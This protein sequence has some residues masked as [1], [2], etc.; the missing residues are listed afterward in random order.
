MCLWPRLQ[1]RRGAECG[2]SAAFIG[3]LGTPIL[4]VYSGG[5][6]LVPHLARLAFTVRKSRAERG[7]RGR[8]NARPF[9]VPLLA[10][11]AFTVKTSP[12]SARLFFHCKRGLHV[13]VYNALINF[14]MHTCA[15]YAPPPPTHTN[16]HTQTY[17]HTHTHTLA[18]TCTC[19]HVYTTHSHLHTTYW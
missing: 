5:L 19:M 2:P 11:W 9:L 6:N 8:P 14:L 13:C 17:T 4:C 1:C 12:R 16:T 10:F 7:P 18:H 3:V 15:T